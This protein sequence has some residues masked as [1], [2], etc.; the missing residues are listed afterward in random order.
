MSDGATPAP[1]AD[2]PPPALSVVV[3]ARDEADNLA[4]LVVEIVAA[5]AG[6][7]FEILVVD[8]GSRD[9]TAAVLA[10]LATSEP[11]LRLLAHA[12]PAGQ[13]AAIATGFASARGAVVVTIDGDGQNDP[14]DIPR[15][16]A[17]LEAG[18]PGVGLVA[19]ERRERHVGLG[20]RLASRAANRLRAAVLGDGVADSACGLKAIDADLA[21][22]L[23]YF[24][25]YHRF[26]PALA[27]AEGR[28]IRR[29]DVADR[30]RR[31]GR[32]KTGILDRAVLG[33]LDLV[34][35]WWLTRRRRGGRR[36]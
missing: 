16:V 20:K 11:R 35:V 29:V 32:S 13:S 23:P 1:A 22:R 3:P 33:A 9:A 18:A 27:L 24:D 4:G 10:R 21:R 28:E 5:L 15:L 7:D 30:P 2:R 14:A 17:V 25:G 6:R 19:G 36:R 34:G 8:D 12:A 31:A 26:L